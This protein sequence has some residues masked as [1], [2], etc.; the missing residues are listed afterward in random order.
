M[1]DVIKKCVFVV[2]VVSTHTQHS[3]LRQRAVTHGVGS[4]VWGYVVHGDTRPLIYVLIMKDVV[5]V[6]VEERQGK[7]EKKK[8]EKGSQG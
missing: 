5:T 8:S 4:L 2:S 6:T 3:V 7:E 1:Q